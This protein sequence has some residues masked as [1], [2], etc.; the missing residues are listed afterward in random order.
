MKAIP[1]KIKDRLVFQTD[2]N[3]ESAPP[4]L[5]EVK[6]DQKQCED[7]ELAVVNRT[8]SIR[9]IQHPK[10]HW[11]KT[12]KTCGNTYNPQTGKYDL[13]ATQVRTFFSAFFKDQDK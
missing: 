9:L 10:N 13:N 7:C 5:V 3:L 6:Y 11:R 12:C 4:K 2:K 1:P 8:I